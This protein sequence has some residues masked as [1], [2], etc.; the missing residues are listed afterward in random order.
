MKKV[1]KIP[2]GEGGIR[3]RIQ[4]PD[5][6]WHDTDENGNLLGEDSGNAE[7]KHQAEAPSPVSKSPTPKV[8]SLPAKQTA[9]KSRRYVNFSIQISQE[10][11][12]LLSDYV[13]WRSLFKQECSKGGFLLKLGLDT[14][15]KDREFREFLSKQG[16]K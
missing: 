16:F 9:E 6:L 2:D 12:K 3:Y 11:Y 5:G 8:R 13:H 15:R 4:T 1:F 10:D 14:I 7:D